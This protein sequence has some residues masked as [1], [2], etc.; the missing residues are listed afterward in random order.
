MSIEERVLQLGLTLPEMQAPL[1]NYVLARVSGDWLYV[2]GHLG[3]RDGVIVTG[4]VDNDIG[5]NE[6]YELARAAAIDILSSARQALG[7]LD[8]L[9]GV[10][11][12]TGFVNSGPDFTDQSAIV[13]GASDVL[14]EV[15]GPDSGRHARSAVGVAQLPKGAAVEIEAIFELGERSESGA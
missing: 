15:F 7:T 8:R 6:A 11:K 4:K 1:A 5:R 14:L 2:S 9:G 3:K 13:N 10:V 12:V